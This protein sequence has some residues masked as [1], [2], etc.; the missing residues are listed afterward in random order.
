MITLVMRSGSREPP[1]SPVTTRATCQ[2]WLGVVAFWGVLSQACN[3]RF[4]F[5]TDRGAGGSLGGGGLPAE[6]GSLGGGGLPAAGGSP[7]AAGTGGTA[8]SAGATTG[9]GASD[10]CGDLPACPL[11]LRCV[12]GACAQC[13]TNADCAPYGLSRCDSTTARCVECVESTD[14]ED[15]SVCD[16]SSNHC[17]PACHEYEDCPRGSHGCDERRGVCVGHRRN[18]EG[19]QDGDGDSLAFH[20]VSLMR[21]QGCDESKPV[22]RSLL[23]FLVDP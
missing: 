7:M 17:L 4:E 9:G 18:G 10:A 21:G 19:E 6:G 22:R 2:R 3:E 23:S 1:I 11:P 13:G 14:C 12:D 5:D 16:T 15:G 8:G 20:S